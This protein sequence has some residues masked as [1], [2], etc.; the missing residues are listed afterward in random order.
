[1]TLTEVALTQCWTTFPDRQ[2]LP[3]PS[4]SGFFDV[5]KRDS[6]TMDVTTAGDNSIK[7]PRAA[8]VGAL[9]YLIKEGHVEGNPC[10][11]RNKYDNPG[12]LAQAAAVNGTQT[13]QYVLPILQAMGLVAVNSN[14]PNTTWL[15]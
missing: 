3:L 14:K 7:V 15:V 6:N 5:T 8:F 1:M 9:D 2:R 4:Q 12:P 13:I 11:V 10:E